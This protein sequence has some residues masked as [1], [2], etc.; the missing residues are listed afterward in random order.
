MA[1][2]PKTIFEST[3]RVKHVTAKSRLEFKLYGF[4]PDNVTSKVGMRTTGVISHY[5]AAA[6][7]TLDTIRYN[8]HT[9]IDSLVVDSF[10]DF[11][12]NIDKTTRLQVVSHG[13][14]VE[15]IHIIS[16]PSRVKIRSF[17]DIYVDANKRNWVK[18]SNIGSLDF[19]IGKDNI[20][21]ERPL[22]WKGLVYAVKKLSEKMVAYGENGV[23]F[24]VPANN[25]Y[26]LNTIYKI[27]LK[28]KNAVGGNDTIH[29]FIDKI[30][31]LWKLDQALERLD[32]SEYLSTMSSSLVM[33]Y[34]ELNSLLYICDGEL[35]YVYNPR[36]GSL[37]RCQ[38]NITG[39]ASQGGILYVAASESIVTP[40]FMFCTDIYD[41][42][43]RTL[44]TV[45]S[46]EIGIGTD[47]QAPIYAAIDY[48]KNI[49]ELFAVTPWVNFQ[50]RGLVII[51]AF[52]R[53]FRFRIKTDSY[54][55]FTLD[56][57]KINGIIHK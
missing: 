32:Y 49:N 25:A 31:Q 24:L 33:T 54:E 19:T 51:P 53:E 29:F 26:G 40:S 36:L 1:R 45:H 38:S 48:K 16:E 4:F 8:W 9:S 15:V 18:W 39:I 55:W 34:D 10:A 12:P 46:L 3:K 44:K 41:L 35:G 14:F 30:G 21:G 7:R 50:N 5:P 42:G 47:L 11:N 22:D 37:G 43:T 56:Y 6:V 13:N 27:G 28:G 20:A 57:L 17:A 23:S 52:G 2:N